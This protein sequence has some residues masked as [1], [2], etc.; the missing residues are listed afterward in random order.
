MKHFSYLPTFVPGK[1][2]VV[3]CR[4]A[5]IELSTHQ[6]LR[7]P[8]LLDPSPLSNVVF[9]GKSSTFPLQLKSAVKI[10]ER[11]RPTMEGSLL[12]SG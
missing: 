4:S 1:F 7:F 8:S 11:E 10:T 9:Y 6:R 3:E 2:C 12:R 5:V